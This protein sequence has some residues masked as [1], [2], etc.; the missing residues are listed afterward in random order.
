MKAKD[1]KEYILKLHGKLAPVYCYKMDIKEPEEYI[2]LQ[3]G[4]ENYA[5][6]YDDT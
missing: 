3:G 4:K 5:Q 1:N 6:F 2:S